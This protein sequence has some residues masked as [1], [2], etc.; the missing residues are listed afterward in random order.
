[1]IVVLGDDSLEMAVERLTIVAL[2]DDSPE[3]A[4]ERLTI[5]ALGDD[6]LEMAGE[7]LTIVAGRPSGAEQPN[8]PEMALFRSQAAPNVAKPSAC[9][10]GTWAKRRATLLLGPG[11]LRYRQTISVHPCSGLPDAGPPAGAP[12]LAPHHDI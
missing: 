11:R 12:G 8:R 5:V 7:R 10:P 6:S 9:L 4:V 1:M 2:G 3:M